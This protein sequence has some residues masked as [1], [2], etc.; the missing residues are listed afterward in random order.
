L[1]S[2]W[3]SKIA[4]LNNRPLN[5]LELDFAEYATVCCKYYR[6]CKGIVAHSSGSQLVSYKPKISLS[7]G[8]NTMLNA[9]KYNCHTILGE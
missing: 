1:G 8:Q 7:K 5:T 4:A 3:S 9:F 2:S 6:R